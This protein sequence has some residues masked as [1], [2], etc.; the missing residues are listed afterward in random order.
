MS[1]GFHRYYPLSILIV[2][3]VIYLSL[4]N[5]ADAGLEDFNLWDKAVHAIMYLGI[6]MAFWFEYLQ[7]HRNV[8]RP[9]ALLFT[10]L[11][12]IL[13]GGALELLQKYCT[14]CRSGEWADFLADAIGVIAGTA[15]GLL[16]EKPFIQRYLRHPRNGKDDV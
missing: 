8:H 13:L 16:I 11:F 14:T 15:V 2:L 4:F 3:T 6:S 1:S 9:S 12:P 7:N 5:P 10:V